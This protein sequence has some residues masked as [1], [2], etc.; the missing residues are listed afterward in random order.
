M[1]FVQNITPFQVV[2]MV[3]PIVSH[4]TKEMSDKMTEPNGGKSVS[5]VFVVG[6]GGKI[7]GFTESLAKELAINND[8][9]ALRGEEVLKEIDFEM[10]GVKKDS[11][12][13]TPIGIC[14][15][16][17]DQ[18]NN[19]IFVN[20]NREQIKLYDNNKLAIVDCAMQA[21]FPNEALFPRRG[22]ELNYTINGKHKMQRGELGEAAVIT[23]NG[24]VAG[25]N[26]PIHAGDKIIIKESTIG[27]EASLEINQLIEYDS[28][29]TV[30]VNDKKVVLP[31]FAEVNGQLQSG[32]YDIKD[33]DNIKLLNYYTVGQI[34]EFMDVILK[35]DM[36][37]YVNN[38][39]AN[40]YDRVF[41]NFS[42]IWT[43]E[44]LQLSEVLEETEVEF[45]EDL[46]EE[47]FIEESVQAPLNTK[48]VIESPQENLTTEIS[49]IVNGSPIRMTGKQSYIYVDI[50]D[51]INFDLS[52][53]KGKSVATLI[54]GRKAD[55]TELL[56][57]GDVLEIYWVV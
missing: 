31:K 33:G 13:V 36:N 7:P 51:Y 16:F 25:I 30:V 57:N 53:S 8:R 50:F 5:A 38:K 34:A 44:E 48:K 19:F 35:K 28:S 26:T 39:K 3:L 56:N 49:V 32:Y 40:L 6:G 46:P 23:L 45:Y 20:F 4:M 37:L 9:V 22:K 42:V 54:N 18:K 11:L 47:D 27:A 15:N 43:M 10:Q 52:V 29:I 12:L 55:Y 21:N 41:E 2:D 17:Y 1:V 14:L 24:E